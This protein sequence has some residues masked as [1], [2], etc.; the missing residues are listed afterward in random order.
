MIED[1]FK[2]KKF[3]VFALCETKLAGQGVQ[4]WDEQRVIVSGVSERCRAREGGGLIIANRLWGRVKEYK[5]ASSRIVWVKLNIC[6][7][8]VMV[9]S[10]FGPGMEKSESER[11][12]F[13]GILT[14][15]LQ[16]FSRKKGCL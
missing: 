12:Q 1:T 15:A 13:W 7:E 14:S 4:D 10:A 2:E 16:V 11:E 9:V 5:C 8:K 3:G 6:R